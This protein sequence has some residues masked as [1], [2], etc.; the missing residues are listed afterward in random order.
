MSWGNFLLFLVTLAILL[1][2]RKAAGGAKWLGTVC[3]ALAFVA[4]I[5][6]AASPPG[7]SWLAGG[8][9]WFL[10]IIGGI[11]GVAGPLI[12]GGILLVLTVIVVVDVAISR[13]GDS[14][15]HNVLI[16]VPVLAIIAAG[17]VA[18]MWT[19]IGDTVQTAGGG[20]I[21]RAIGG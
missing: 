14:K 6:L 5:F 8:I 13:K 17:P 12:A 21:S 15:T 20:G 1:I 3:V 7:G 4:G 2:V 11:T 19:S 16:I 18:E 10:G 9:R